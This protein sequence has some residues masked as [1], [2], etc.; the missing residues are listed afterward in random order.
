MLPKRMKISKSSADSLKMLKG[1]TGVTPNLICRIA[2]LLS[3][4]DG[5]QGG[6]RTC[7]Q[8]GNEFNSS[9]LFGDHGLLFECLLRELHGELDTKACAS[10]I[11]SHIEV[12]LDRLRKSKTLLELVEHSGLTSANVGTNM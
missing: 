6:H 8:D 12:G 2:L 9:T 11:A 10:T 7:D 4:E 3:I 1:R 5:E